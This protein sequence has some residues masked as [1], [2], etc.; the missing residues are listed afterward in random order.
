MTAT[1]YNSICKPQYTPLVPRSSTSKV[2][3]KANNNY[4]ASISQNQRTEK[5][6][7]GDD[8]T[9]ANK[10]LQDLVRRKIITFNI[11][12]MPAIIDEI[13]A[14]DIFEAG[15]KTYSGTQTFS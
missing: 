4:N 12:T 10:P 8:I 1:Q 2:H 6:E 11:L 3:K 13:L 9:A 14:P 5:G 7:M 15:R